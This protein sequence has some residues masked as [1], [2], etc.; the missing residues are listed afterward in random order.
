MVSALKINL[1]WARS[2]NQYTIGLHEQVSLVVKQINVMFKSLNIIF[3]FATNFIAEIEKKFNNYFNHIKL[4]NLKTLHNTWHTHLSHLKKF[5]PFKIGE[6]PFYLYDLLDLEQLESAANYIAKNLPGIMDKF[7]QMKQ[8][9][10]SVDDEKIVV[11]K[12]IEKLRNESISTF[13][14]IDPSS[15]LSES[16]KATASIGEDLDKISN[17]SP[18]NIPEIYSSHRHQYSPTIFNNATSIYNYYEKLQSFK[19]NLM[20]GS[21]EVFKKI[22]DLQMQM[23]KVKDELRIL[24]ETTDADGPSFKTINLINK[25]EDLLS[26]TIDL[27]LIFGFLIIERRRQF[28]WYDF[29]AKGVVANASEQFT[30][31]ID[32]EKLFR[33]IWNK[34]FGSFLN[35][36]T[37]EPISSTLPNL[38][39]TLV[40][41]KFEKFSILN[42]LTIE[43]TDIT[44]YISILDSSDV[45]KNFVELLNNN[46][47][48]L[49]AST[50]SM[51][52]ITKLITSLSTYTAISKEEKLRIILKGDE[53]EEQDLDVKL[54]NGLKSRIK[55]LENLLHQQQYKN[56]SNWPV[57]SINTGDNKQSLIVDRVKP[58]FFSSKNDPTQLLE[59]NP[60]ASIVKSIH[61]PSALD[62]TGL[63]KHLDNIR[64]KKENAEVVNKNKILD[65][66]NNELQNQ[67]RQLS[68][69]IAKLKKENEILVE[70][71][72]RLLDTTKTNERKMQDVQAELDALKDKL[73]RK[74]KD[75]EDSL[76]KKEEEF[77]LYK[78]NNKLDSTEIQ[79]LTKKLEHKDERISDLQLDLANITV[80][81]RVS[82]SELTKLRDLVDEMQKEL[83]DAKLSKNDLLCNMS[84]KD[85]DYS[86]ERNELEK[87]IK[88]LREQMNEVQLKLD[89]VSEDY[90]NLM[91]LTE[92][93]DKSN[94][95]L[96]NDLNNII[97]TLLNSIKS[98]VEH[99]FE[100][101]VEYCLV[102]ESM[103]LLLVKENNEYKITR[104][105]GLRS[106]KGDDESSEVGWTEKPSTEVIA[107]IKQ[108]KSWVSDIKNFNSILPNESRIIEPLDPESESNI[109]KQQSL[110]LISLF[111]EDFG[112]ENSKFDEFYK[113]IG[114]KEN[115]HL[116]GDNPTT[117]FFLNA[118]NKRFRDVEG[119]AKRQTKENKTKQ[120]EINKLLARLNS[121]ISMNEFQV[122]DLVL[123][124]PTR[125]DRINEVEEQSQP[126]AAFNIGA[127]HYFLEIDDAERF[128]NKDWMV[129]RVTNIVENKVTD[130]NVDDKKLN[131]FQL[132]VGVVWFMV[133]A[134]EEHT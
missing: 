4:V 18:V 95:L 130:E 70:E 84:A 73:T 39:I 112:S 85:G 36:L 102:L 107:E 16:N 8:V 64:L 128:K 125:I 131:P 119:F 100:V 89:D 5:P 56:L 57:T 113:F 62:T 92:K 98:L 38:D 129:G 34:K 101:F 31:I 86:K 33:K 58:D 74:K 111:N 55:K 9:I 40:G 79:S 77:R 52:K 3:Q 25:N 42:D 121:K 71:N 115:I 6:K 41:H 12:S 67:N 83:K 109:Y 66:E 17:N 106:K 49:I 94:D 20:L 75:F 51:K 110:K 126:W 87:T 104:V 44:S 90:E 11:D 96:I 14:D 124:L 1:G 105:K 114:F 88:Q 43:R 63:D 116:Q 82:Q 48:D 133:T 72:T 2:L 32:H 53:S 45:S 123:F 7:T 80:E 60:G 120:L 122:E 118:I 47:K 19:R 30:T 81:N 132:S 99:N 29:F 59:R 78:L 22:A 15:L 13:K 54:I 103:G 65:D 35:L 108:K 117:R 46:Y 76:D 61:S 91:E 127:P 68:E 69:Q 37:K 10:K 23:V 26:L 97:I 27:P 50:N 93:K 21:T 28:E 24:T 134:K